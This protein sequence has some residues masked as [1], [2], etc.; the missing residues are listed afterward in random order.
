MHVLILGAGGMLGRRVTEAL[1]SGPPGSLEVERLTLVDVVEVSAAATGPVTVA[2]VGDLAEPGVA[3][4]LVAGRPDV[5]VHLA[6]VV[7]GEAE[8]RFAHGYRSN[9]D[10]TRSL[11]EAI[12]AE[13]VREPYRP[14]VV[15]AS[16]VAVF[17][18]PFPETIPEDF[19]TAPLTSYGAQKAIGELLLCDYSR[20]GYLDGIGVRLPT[21]C[22]RPGQPNRAASGFFS[23][24]LREP[25]TGREAVLP[26]P[27]TVRH[28]FASPRSAV[29]NLLRAITLDSAP[30]LHRRVLSMP[31][32]SATVGEQLAALRAIA[33]EKAVRLVRREPDEAI[34]RIVESWPRRTAADR[35]ER[36]GFTAEE[37]M[38]EIV[39]V[40]VED[41]LDGTVGTPA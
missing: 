14:R 3:E 36:L 26:V 13:G 34:A 2:H 40:H 39:R 23:N 15:F 25:L 33:G 31:G 10:G 24:I 41:E 37:S 12:R 28:V 38:E 7:S 16:S 8:R 9:L 21:I 11:F 35:A 18:P 4:R 22:V 1:R 5:V 27:D 19:Q 17:G 29:R 20:R 32:L 6:A 30:L